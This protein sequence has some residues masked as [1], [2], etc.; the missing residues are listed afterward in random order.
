MNVQ[1]SRSFLPEIDTKLNE[2]SINLWKINDKARKQKRVQEL[3]EWA[4]GYVQG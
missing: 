4:K 3:N 2:N 1:L